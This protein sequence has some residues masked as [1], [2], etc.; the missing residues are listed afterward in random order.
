MVSPKVSTL[1]RPCRPYRGLLVTGLSDLDAGRETEPSPHWRPG[2]IRMARLERA[3]SLPHRCQARPG[4]VRQV[5]PF[6]DGPFFPEIA[7]FLLV[8]SC[9]QS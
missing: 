7:I 6:S 3:C 1:A 9:V 4:I 2:M 8:F 5:F